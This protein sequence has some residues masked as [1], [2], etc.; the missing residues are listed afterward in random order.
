MMITCDL[1]REEGLPSIW[2]LIG[3]D[4]LLCTICANKLRDDPDYEIDSLMMTIRQKSKQLNK[5]PSTPDRGE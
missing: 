5:Y 2:V 4:G 3:Y 1:C